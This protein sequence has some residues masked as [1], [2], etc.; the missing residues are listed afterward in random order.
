MNTARDLARAAAAA[1]LPQTLKSIELTAKITRSRTLSGGITATIPVWVKPAIGGELGRS[2]ESDNI[3]KMIF[4]APVGTK[5]AAPCGTAP[6][7]LGEI[8]PTS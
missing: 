6:S 1:G 4:G 8:S 3:V 7:P 5:K 2:S